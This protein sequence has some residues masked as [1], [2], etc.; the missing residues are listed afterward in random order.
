[1][2]NIKSLLI[3]KRLIKKVEQKALL[4]ILVAF[5]F[6]SNKYYSQVNYVINPSFEQVDSCPVFVFKVNAIGWDTL[7]NGGGCEPDLMTSCYSSTA[8]AF[9]L[10]VPVNFY[11]RNYQTP[12][13]GSNYHNLMAFR[14]NTAIEGRDYLQGNLK[15]KLDNKNYCVTFYTNL[16]NNSRYAIDRMGA[17]IDDGSISS[18]ACQATVTPA[19]IVSA[20]LSFLSDTLNWIKVQG[21]YNANAN[22]TKITIGN[23]NSIA[24]THTLNVGTALFDP[25]SYYFIDDVSVVEMDLKPFAGR[26]T[27]LCVGDSVFIGRTPEV[28]LECIWFNNST[29]IATGGGLYVKPSTSQ[30]YIVNQ[31]VC[32]IITRDTVFVQVKP[33]FTGSPQIQSTAL[34][35]CPDDTVNLLVLNTPAIGTNY[36]WQGDLSLKSYTNISTQATMSQTVISPGFYNIN[37][38]VS[39]DGSG[40][41][42][43]FNDRDTIKIEVSDTCFKELMIPNV[44]TPNDDKVNDTWHF[45]MPFGSKLISASVYNRW[46]TLIYNIDKSLLS[47]SSKIST[48]NWDGHTTSGEVCS[49]G[50]YFYTIKY[51]DKFNEA[52]E[53]KGNLSL[54]R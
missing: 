40:S 6:L 10:G 17:V 28:G 1:M 52:K 32:G 48:I 26:D 35:L 27:I 42:C 54:I 25:Y 3:S 21:I 2:T 8:A 18:P 11:G 15:K 22:E 37:V 24:G 16:S 44:F 43:P 31:D 34:N 45:K 38:L 53:I 29:Q 12:R 23:F 33:K 46:G 30:N 4:Y 20:N 47:E 51:T 14:P 5:C 49:S 9:I 13:T 36:N 19:S 7:S 39:N 50:V 41:F